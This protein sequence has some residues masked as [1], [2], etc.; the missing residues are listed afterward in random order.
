MVNTKLVYKQLFQVE[1]GFMRGGP[2]YLL[3]GRAQRAGSGDPIVTL[4]L[5]VAPP[6]LRDPGNK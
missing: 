2:G 3:P 5:P 4:S 1:I 6:S